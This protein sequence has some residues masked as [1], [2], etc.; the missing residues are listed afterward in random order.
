MGINIHKLVI[1]N[2]FYQNLKSL[3]MLKFIPNNMNL[4]CNMKTPFLLYV[5]IL[6]YTDKAQILY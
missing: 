5:I 1:I 6:F 3:S 4:N 2:I